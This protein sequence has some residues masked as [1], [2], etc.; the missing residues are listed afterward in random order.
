[1][2]VIAGR[3]RGRKLMAPTGLAVRPTADRMKEALFSMLGDRVQDCSFLDLFAGSGAIGIEAVSRGA[4]FA[5]FADKDAKLA[6]KN[7]KSCGFEPF[8]LVL[9][10]DW[11]L[12]AKRFKALSKRFDII[13]LDPPYHQGLCP[14]A[15]ICSFELGLL[16]EGGLF[17]AECASDELEEVKSLIEGHGRLAAVKEKAYT[18]AAFLFINASPRAYP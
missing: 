13:F 14:E 1:M 11:R 4:S 17:V 18:T 16:A 6:E 10:M 7:I 3:S 15:A 8:S 2:R 12:A 5:A 9:Q